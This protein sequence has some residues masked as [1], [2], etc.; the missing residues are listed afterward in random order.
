[1]SYNNTLPAT[2][3]SIHGPPKQPVS[4]FIVIGR[5]D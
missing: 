3:P 5:K 2:L 4:N 1:M